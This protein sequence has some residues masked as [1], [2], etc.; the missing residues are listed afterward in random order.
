MRRIFIIC[1]IA[2]LSLVLTYGFAGATVTGSCAACHTM[3]NSQ[4]NAHM[5]FL[6]PFETD[7]T[8]K[9]TLLRGTCIGCHGRGSANN[10]EIFG[11]SNTPQVLHSNA[12][13][14]AGGN[15]G[16][17][18]AT[19]VR[20]AADSGATQNSVGHNVIDLTAT[21]Q[22][23]TLTTPPGDENTTG[24][25]NTNFTCSGTNGCHGVRTVADKYSAVSGAHHT[26][27]TV[28]KYGLSLDE[29]GQ[30]ST[31]G[32]SFRF[33]KGV[34]GA[35]DAN[36]H[37]TVA[38][39]DHNEYK[40]TST[41]GVSEDTTISSPGAAGSISGLCAEC[42]GNFHGGSADIGTA[43]GSWIRHPVDIVLPNTGEYQYYNGRVPPAAAT[44]SLD[45]PVARADT[46]N[47]TN[48]PSAKNTATPGT[49]DAIVMCLSCHKAHASAN[50]DIL[51]WNYE[52]LNAGGGA[53][54]TRCF[55]CHTTKDTGG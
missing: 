19:K 42:H 34:K 53:N 39:N 15:F 21:Y 47:N 20:D 43:A 1:L 18:T 4:N 6:A 17:V 49:N 28:L 10:I 26:N 9:G 5:I 33:L 14:L 35:E 46:I 2:L 37:A 30:G 55:I 8:P 27:D 7:T 24:I 44:Y 41:G 54:T 31:T 52:D 38:A 48:Y 22:E 11:T 45:A 40:G 51:R 13:D 3:H 25:T 29:T 23:T 36:W 50:A 32:L 16:Y 12:T